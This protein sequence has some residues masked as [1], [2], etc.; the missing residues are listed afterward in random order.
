VKLYKGKQFKMK[1]FCTFFLYIFAVM[2]F[3]M[4]A[5]SPSDAEGYKKKAI[6]TGEE[7][8]LEIPR[9]VS[10]RSGEVYMR[11]GPGTRYPVRWIY[12][13]KNFPVEIIQEF[14][15]WRKVRDHEG[16]EGWVHQSLITGRRYALINAGHNIEA[17]R[18]DDI[19][20]RVTMRLE[21]E[22]IAKISECNENWCALTHSGYN[23]WVEKKYLW[24]V[25][26]QER[27]N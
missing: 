13:R 12:K 17:F 7:T 21:P 11:S 18:D 6:G 19:D 15:T 5:V 27:I 14:D 22:V 4:S 2:C 26:D 10:F 8:G 16:A 24:G 3:L 1:V 20:A 25:Y 23:G 9:F